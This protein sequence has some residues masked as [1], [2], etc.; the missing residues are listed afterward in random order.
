MEDAP[1]QII[2][3]LEAD[4]G[5]L[6]RCR[7]EIDLVHAPLL[8]EAIDTALRL[9]ATCWIDL[10]MVTFLDLSVVHELLRAHRAA[11]RLGCRLLIAPTDSTAVMLPFELLGLLDVLPFVQRPSVCRPA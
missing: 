2:V 5:A 8:R 4:S 1:Q 7:G 3:H 9:D 6:V 11:M 10:R